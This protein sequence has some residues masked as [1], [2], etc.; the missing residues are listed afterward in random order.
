V[1]F[2]A[3]YAALLWTLLVAVSLAWNVYHQRRE[4]LDLARLQADAY[5]NKD[6]TFRSWATAH[7]GVYVRPT[8][9]MPP[10]PYLKAPDRDVVT[11][12]GIRLTLINPAYMMRQVLQD[13]SEPFGIRGHLTSLTLLNPHNAPD[14]WEHEALLA[15][16]HG[17]K[18]VEEMTVF[19]GKSVLRYMRPVYVEE[20]CIKCH[21]SVNYKVGD[22]RGGIS[23]VVD[24][25]P[26]QAAS[27]RTV[28]GMYYTHSLIWLV[29][30]LG[31]GV[32]ARRGAQRA[33]ERERSVE[34]IRLNEKRALA[35]L[36]LDEKA[37]K[38]DE[39]TLLQ[40]GLE[41]AE[42]LTSS[43]IAY[44]HFINDDQ[45]TIELVTWS[46][47]TLQYCQAAFDRHYPLDAAG[48]WAD[49]ARTKSAVV[50]NDYQK[51]ANK[52]GYPEG[53]AHLI[54]HLGVPVVEG[55][56][57]RLIMGVGNKACD[58]D[59]TD[60]RLLQ[61]IANDLWKVVRR[62]RVEA[63]LKRAN[64]E[65]ER[66]VQERT[67]ELSIAN[68]H[69]SGSVAELQLHQREM[70]TINQLNDM[71][72]T[73]QALDEAYRVIEIAARELF[74]VKGGGLMMLDSNRQ[75][76]D[77]VVR[78]GE[79]ACEESFAPENCWAMRQGQRHCVKDVEHELLCKHFT[80]PPTGG[81]LCMPFAAQGEIMG[82]LYLEMKAG[83]GPVPCETQLNL[84]ETVC[85]VVKLG[86]SNISLRIALR[87]QATH[88]LLTGLYNRRYLDEALPREIHRAAR[89]RSALCAVMM[90]IDYFKRFNDAHG[91]EAGDLVLR[92]IGRLLLGSLRKSDIACRYGGEEIAI[93]MPDSSLDDALQRV[94]QIRQQIG[95][96]DIQLG[97]VALGRVTVSAGVAQMTE[98]GETPDHL[99]R[100]ADQAL[101]AAKLGGR[102][103]IVAYK[104]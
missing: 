30:L 28:N 83:E 59:Q 22:I 23:T 9:K 60:I 43:Q 80:S 20:G 69:L 16:E 65:M 54:R 1:R 51:L 18:K 79:T 95:R 90:D 48:V 70:K 50:H 104:A 6:L 12:G 11:T 39:K 73:C 55:D 27:A 63:E 19:D 101:Y 47:N 71:L 74:N 64:E 15:F 13:F 17:A 57:V 14:Q 26:L 102:D 82:M 4:T 94:E 84:A 87:E 44:L 98:S 62:R 33:A 97:A 24:M 100:A 89:A 38:L 42:R 3:T 2:N 10:N 68:E 40:E 56:K 61:M 99:L 32:S 81:Y 37:D 46:K 75:Y 29:G 103:R 49:C 67:S 53:H 35:L 21:G 58:Y 34:A 76:L 41:E 86:L 66:R 72:Q 36:A 78:W 93:I 96:L 85:E 91:H 52:H 45:Q 88:D 31:I 8:E 25:E 7:G 77:A 5:I 92:E